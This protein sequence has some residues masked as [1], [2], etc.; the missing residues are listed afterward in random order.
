MKR[1]E[2]IQLRMT[3]KKKPSNTDD[4]GM[5]GKDPQVT[6]VREGML[7]TQGGRVTFEPGSADLSNRAKRNIKIVADLI[8]GTTTRL[9][10]VATPRR[11]N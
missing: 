10:F 2:E 9:R 1:L 3:T 8:R 11:W 5:E 7:F 4:P 6:R